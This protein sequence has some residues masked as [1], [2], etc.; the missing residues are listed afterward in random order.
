MPELERE[1]R[2]LAANVELPADRDLWPAVEARLGTRPPRPWLRLIAPVAVA[3]AVAVGIAFAVPPA[4]SAILRFFG[5]E[6][7]SIVRVEQLPPVSVHPA[8]FGTRTTLDAAEHDLGF[9]PRLVDVGAPA[10]LYLDPSHQAF[11]AVYGSPIRLRLEET[12]FGI[13][14]KLVSVTQKIDRVNVNRD[15]GI[16][17][18]GEHVFSDFFGQPRLAGNALLWRHD[19]VTYRLEGRLTKQQAL[20]IARTVGSG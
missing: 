2:S 7:V 11:L 20:R 10:R 9:R 4:R 19:G 14:D 12:R 8:V 17:L 15:P 1:L 16:W 13:F 5:V 18:A 3:I 6:G